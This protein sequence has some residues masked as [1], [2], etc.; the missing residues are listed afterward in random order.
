MRISNFSQ[1]KRIIRIKWK[2]SISLLYA[3][4]KGFLEDRKISSICVIPLKVPLLH[5]YFH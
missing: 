2:L 4:C 5:P 1:N 3:V